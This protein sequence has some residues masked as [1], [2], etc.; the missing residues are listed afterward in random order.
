LYA[1]NPIAG[2]QFKVR[3]NG[4]A[5]AGDVNIMTIGDEDGADNCGIENA[6]PIMLNAVI[7]ATM[8]EIMK[9]QEKCASIITDGSAKRR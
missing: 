3:V 5:R 7:E 2:R 9:F 1:N 4:P 6:Y 8:P